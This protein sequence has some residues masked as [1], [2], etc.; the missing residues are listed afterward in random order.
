M[1]LK[2]FRELN[3]N[4]NNRLKMKNYSILRVKGTPSSYAPFQL[5]IF[6]I[7]IYRLPKV[8]YI[9]SAKLSR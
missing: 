9:Y 1:K 7:I 3:N 6:S 2:I 8:I 5:A 4:K